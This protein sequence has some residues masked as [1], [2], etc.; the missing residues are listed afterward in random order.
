MTLLIDCHIFDKNYQG[1][2]TFLKGLIVE[3]INFDSINLVLASYDV[4]SLKNEFGI[5]DKLQYEKFNTKNKYHRLFYDVP[6]V[7]RKTKATHAL[8]NYTCP[9]FVVKGCKYLTVIHDVLFLDYPKYFPLKYRL[10]HKFL[11]KHS[12]RK[13]ENI[14]TVSD[15]SRKRINSHFNLKI[16]SSNIIPNA[17]DNKFKTLIDKSISRSFLFKELK[18]QNF[19]LYVSRIET[20]KNHEFILNWFMDKKIYLEGFQLI[21]IGKFS[22]EECKMENIFSEAKKKSNGFFKHIP[23]VSSEYLYHLNN[24]AKVSVFPSLCE[25]F[26]IPPLESAVLMTPTVCS[27]QTALIDFSF[28]E[29]YLIE[30]NSDKFIEKIEDILFDHSSH[31]ANFI[32]ISEKI[33]N[34]YNWAQSAQFLL[35][36]I[37]K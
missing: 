19:I 8:F 23:Q 29:E 6:R 20:R 36:I 12:I 34:Q 26:G 9:F 16:G 13:S 10:T 1:I 33:K 22:F 15:Y 28:F 31:K 4:N 37:K 17:V 2:R 5:H 18:I 25:G 3:L 24:G 14:L 30:P 7:I 32:K 27:K 11:F 35:N 21:F